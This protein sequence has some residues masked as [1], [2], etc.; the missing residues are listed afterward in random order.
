MVRKNVNQAAAAG[1]RRFDP[2]RR[3]MEEG[4]RQR[5][6]GLQEAVA[7]HGPDGSRGCSS[8]DDLLPYLSDEFEPLKYAVEMTGTGYMHRCLFDPFVLCMAAR[9]DMTGKCVQFL[10]DCGAPVDAPDAETGNT[11]LRFAAYRGNVKAVNVLLKAGAS[12]TTTC[13]QRQAVGHTSMFVYVCQAL[14]NDMSENATADDYLKVAKAFVAAGFDA[15]STMKKGKVLSPLNIACE[16]APMSD[17]AMPKFLLQQGCDVNTKADGL[18]PLW[19]ACQKGDVKLVRL[20][21]KHGAD[22]RITVAFNATQRVD[23]GTNAFGGL[24][25]VDGDGND[26]HVL[27]VWEQSVRSG[28]QTRVPMAL[29]DHEASLTGDRA[30]E[31]LEDAV[32]RDSPDDYTPHVLKN[33]RTAVEKY[34][35]TGELRSKDMPLKAF[36]LAPGTLASSKLTVGL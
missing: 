34:R 16:F 12:M 25:N 6:K 10:I 14:G 9:D 8:I 18:S 36:M 31:P 35:T 15:K 2:K 11:P 21:L 26:G 7:R 22:T 19:F 27:Y 24:G 23:G 3:F 32:A 28:N 4:L 5:L 20:L 1:E 13:L 17:L 33:L 29:F 30:L